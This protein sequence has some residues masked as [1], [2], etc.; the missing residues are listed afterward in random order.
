MSA[1]DKRL[2]GV[3]MGKEKMP[4]YNDSLVKRTFATFLNEFK[5][6]A[7]RK[8][9]EKDRRVDDLVLI[10][11]SKTTQ[12]LMKGKLPGDGSYKLMVDRHVALF[13]RLIS[14]IL[15][16]NDWARERPELASRLQTMEKKLLVHDQDLAADSTRNGG[17]GGHSIEVEVPLSHELKDMPLAL[18]VSRVFNMP[19]GQVQDDINRNR[20]HW[21]EKAALQDLK[22]YQT[23]L[24]LNTKKTLNSDDF[25]TE[26]AY[27]SWKKSEAPEI[28]QMMLAIM[29]SNM[30]LAK[31][32]SS[33]NV[34]HF[35]SHMDHGSRDS[36]YS[37]MS[38]KMSE[39]ENSNNMYVID[40]PVDMSGLSLGSAVEEEDSMPF[41]FIPQDP[42]ANY[43]AVLKACLAHDLQELA[44]K[45]EEGSSPR[46]F[47]KQSTELLSE[48]ALRWRI[49]S[50][51]R[52]VLFLDVVKE[53]YT[54]QKI[55]LDTLD[56]AFLYLKEPQIDIKKANRKSMVVQDAVL[57]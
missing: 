53:L 37:D 38:R 25:D 28:S 10:F 9:V 51:S 12:E 14:S 31:M 13:L 43:R 8:S 34:P 18:I 48:T 24:S 35:K 27:E 2:T 41:T 26:D 16:D 22:M 15:K 33:A 3:L 56:A 45:P 1:L 6:P 52:P 54:N 55:D 4:E 49:P 47:S 19:Y 5:N 30:E 11:F 23:S 36:G 57:D 17:A 29:Q 44:D 21:T 46:L 50:F 40:Q 42:R 39:P 20:S 32:T 7:F